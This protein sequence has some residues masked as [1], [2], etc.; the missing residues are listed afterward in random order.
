MY[1]PFLE[2]KHGKTDWVKVIPA[3]FDEVLELKNDRIKLSCEAC[4][5]ASAASVAD[6]Q[7]SCSCQDTFRWSDFRQETHARR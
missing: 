3:A 4:L 6:L 5:A 2:G 7:S 1:L